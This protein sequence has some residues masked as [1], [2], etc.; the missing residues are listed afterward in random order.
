MEKLKIIN[1]TYGKT[2]YSLNILALK[3]NELIE[4]NTKLKEAVRYLAK[5]LGHED[6]MQSFPE[7][8]IKI[9]EILRG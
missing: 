9:N 5:C 3:I 1:P 8:I 7:A 2:E 6:L 4:E